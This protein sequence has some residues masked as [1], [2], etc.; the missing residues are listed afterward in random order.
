M[1]HSLD[2]IYEVY[3]LGV[4]I[5]WW[6]FGIDVPRHLFGWLTPDVSGLEE[7]LRDL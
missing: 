4:M 6:V 7:L 5:N 1:L 3:C 2:D